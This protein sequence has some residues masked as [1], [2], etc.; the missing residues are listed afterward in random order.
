M[1]PNNVL[2]YR[3]YVRCIAQRFSTAR[4]AVAS[5]EFAL[6]GLALFVFTI[7]IINLGD[8]GLTLGA[9]EHGLQAA[10]RELAIQT[11]AALATNGSATCPTSSEIQTYFNNVAAPPLPAATSSTTAGSPIIT[12][13]WVDN[14]LDS[15]AGAPPTLYL[16]LKVAYKWNP[17][18]LPDLFGKG[19]NLA[20]TTVTTVIGPAGMPTC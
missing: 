9:L 3:S 7:A 12:A 17:I 11:T 14:V 18:G 8:L 10:A 16:N 5:I 15:T 4:R 13:T 19:I 1:P 20:L 2:H 6:S